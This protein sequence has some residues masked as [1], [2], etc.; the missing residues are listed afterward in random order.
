[1]SYAKSTICLNCKAEFAANMPRAIE[2][3]Q[4]SRRSHL[5]AEDV[6]EDEGGD[7]GGV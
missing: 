2:K 3:K 6:G 4:I 1:M 5:P 7:D